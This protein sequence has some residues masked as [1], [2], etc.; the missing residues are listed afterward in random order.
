MKQLQEA[1]AIRASIPNTEA[2]LKEHPEASGALGRKQ[3][4]T[5]TAGRGRFQVPQTAVVRKQIRELDSKLKEAAERY[6]LAAVTGTR[7]KN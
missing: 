2:H 5:Q 7:L 3:K 6:E 4:R 1:R